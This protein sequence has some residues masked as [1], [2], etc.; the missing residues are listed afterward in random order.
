[1]LRS[2]VTYSAQKLGQSFDCR[3]AETAIEL[4]QFG[5]SKVGR[6]CLT[7]LNKK[8][9]AISTYDQVRATREY[10]LVRYIIKENAHFVYILKAQ[11][12]QGISVHYIEGSFTNQSRYKGR[13]QGCS[14]SDT[15]TDS[16][17]ITSISL[18]C[19]QPENVA[20]SLVLAQTGSRYRYS[21]SIKE[22]TY[23]LTV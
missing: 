21:T 3:I 1:M 16:Y 9:V 5:F 6:D 12:E 19:N 14:R 22:D 13:S 15:E 4:A 11:Q 8:R 20:V 2:I 18:K 7:T 23:K 17:R 10:N